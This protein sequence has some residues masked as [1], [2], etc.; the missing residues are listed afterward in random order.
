MVG[1]AA[2]FTRNDEVERA[3]E[4]LEPVMQAWRSGDGG[5]MTEYPAGSWGPTEADDLIG[6][7]GFV[8]RRP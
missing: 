4:I 3:W 6:R 7:D 2:L 8:W 5:P 1:D